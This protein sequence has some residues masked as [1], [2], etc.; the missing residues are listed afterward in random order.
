M[1]YDPTRWYPMAHY[2]PDWDHPMFFK[3]FFNFQLE[4]Q[5]FLHVFMQKYFENIYN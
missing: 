2:L 1:I 4:E 3:Y 5:T